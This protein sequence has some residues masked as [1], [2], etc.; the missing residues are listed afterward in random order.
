[1]QPD[2]E[3]AFVQTFIRRERRDRWLSK[4]S[5][6]KHRRSFLDRLNHSFRDDL[7]ERFISVESRVWPVDIERCYM[8][9]DESEYDGRHV[10]SAE[11]A[12][13]VSSATFGI[14][15]SFVPGMLA[16]YKDESPSDIVW[17]GR[18]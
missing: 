16:C 11:A 6:S 3:T 10:T 7:D 13:A 12:D 4:L 8:I 9:A 18:E 17:L 5:L 2:H 14:V 15:V 1:M